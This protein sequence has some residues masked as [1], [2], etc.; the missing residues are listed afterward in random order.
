MSSNLTGARSV[1]GDRHRCSR[2]PGSSAPGTPRRWVWLA[3]VIVSPIFLIMVGLAATSTDPE[4][5]RSI[6][7][8]LSTA[9]GWH[10]PASPPGS[11]VRQG[12]LELSVR[13]VMDS[14]VSSSPYRRVVVVVRVSDLGTTPQ[15]FP[16]DFQRLRDGR[17]RVFSP[18]TSAKSGWLNVA[19]GGEV[20]VPLVF[21]V[22]EDSTAEVL[23][24]RRSAS[25][26]GVLLRLR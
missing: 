21:L 19:P 20:E 18:D 24:F 8:R 14:S 13:D 9:A 5:V 26:R 1:P 11:Q 16:A 22:P 7:D 10:A 15:G 6:P 3:V 4:P 12:D 25:S 2:V 23:E 17:G